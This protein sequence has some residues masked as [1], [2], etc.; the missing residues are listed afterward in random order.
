MRTK[1]SLNHLVEHVEE[2]EY[3]IILHFGHN[4][5]A[6]GLKVTCS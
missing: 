1:M 6:V 4:T 2:F 5:C 3:I